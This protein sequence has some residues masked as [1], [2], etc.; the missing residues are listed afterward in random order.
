MCP[1]DN[2][3]ADQNI[4]AQMGTADVQG[5]ENSED[6]MSPEEL[7]KTL[8]DN[9]NRSFIQNPVHE[10]LKDELINKPEDKL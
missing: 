4:D 6:L 7:K 5:V 2:K 8:S 9:I 1:I 3:I 10:A